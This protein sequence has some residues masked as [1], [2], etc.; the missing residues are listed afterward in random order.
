VSEDFSKDAFCAVFFCWWE[1]VV[2]PYAERSE[3]G[4]E[5]AEYV[6][7]VVVVRLDGFFEAKGPESELDVV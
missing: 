2:Y 3:V 4:S 5:D 1:V 7:R 6:C